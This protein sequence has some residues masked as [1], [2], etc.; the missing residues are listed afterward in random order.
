[1]WCKNKKDALEI[2][3]TR[4]A[5]V[6]RHLQSKRSQSS[7]L[8]NQDGRIILGSDVNAQASTKSNHFALLCSL[9]N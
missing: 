9:I 3:S 8:V 1:M 2:N 4:A 6:N 5:G 7:K